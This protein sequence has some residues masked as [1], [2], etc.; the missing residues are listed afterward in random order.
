SWPVKSLD[1][2]ADGV[3]TWAKVFPHLR[4]A[5]NSTYRAR[6][7]PGKEDQ[8]AQD[9]HA[10]ELPGKGPGPL[11]LPPIK[12]PAGKP[13][14]SK[15]PE[16]L[17]AKPTSTPPAPDSG[18]R[19]FRTSNGRFVD[20]GKGLWLLERDDGQ[21]FRY[22][23]TRRTANYIELRDAAR[24]VAIALYRDHEKH[25]SPTKKQW[26]RGASGKWE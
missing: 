21:V 5:T 24:K 16:K 19:V 10:F 18:R 9:A 7:N 17:T 23:E 8:Q 3:V 12:P 1:P 20:Q 4:K 22:T 25:Y 26:I 11:V 14:V 6:G 13:P 15:P 2:D